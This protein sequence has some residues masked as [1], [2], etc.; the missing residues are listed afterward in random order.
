MGTGN[1]YMPPGGFNLQPLGGPGSFN[2]MYGGGQQN[3]GGVMGGLGG[4]MYG[5]GGGMFNPMN[6]PAFGYSPMAMGGGASPA[7]LGPGP[8]GALAGYSP[9]MQQI[10]QA[11]GLGGG[12]MAP[13]GST[14]Q[15]FGAAQPQQAA[16]SIA[17]NFGGQQPQQPQQQGGTAV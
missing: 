5:G 7:Y 4:A 9:A 15:N 16:G 3:L 2:Q 17:Q 12:G 1:P 11:R 8:G 13:A 10:L 14:A 6:R